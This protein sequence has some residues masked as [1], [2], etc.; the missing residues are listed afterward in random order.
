MDRNPD[1]D[2]RKQ[3]IHYRSRVYVISNILLFHQAM[4][5]LSSEDSYIHPVFVSVFSRAPSVHILNFL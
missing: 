2:P 4:I 1:R 5:Q 3:D